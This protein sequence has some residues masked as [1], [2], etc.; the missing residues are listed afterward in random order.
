MMNNLEL[1]DV[2]LI[3]IDFGSAYTKVAFRSKPRE[4]SQILTDLNLAFDEDHICIPSILASTTRSDGVRWVCGPD[5]DGLIEGDGIKIHRNWKQAL[6]REKGSPSPGSKK[7]SD[8]EVDEQLASF[9][10]DLTARSKED[11]LIRSLARVFEIRPR[12]VRRLVMTHEL[13]PSQLESAARMVGVLGD[14]MGPLPTSSGLAVADSTDTDVRLVAIEFFK[15]LREYVQDYA[16]RNQLPAPDQTRVRICGPAF[17]K[18]TASGTPLGAEL[19]HDI[20]VT[21]GWQ[22]DSEKWFV[23]E[24]S[25]NAIGTLTHGK[26]WLWWPDREPRTLSIHW[27]QM[28]QSKAL[29]SAFSERKGD[30]L[31]CVVDVGAFTTDFAVLRFNTS[32]PD[33]PPKTQS[34]SVRLGI[35]K[36]DEE[37]MAQLPA[38]TASIIKRFNGNLWEDFKRRVY[39]RREPFYYDNKQLCAGTEREIIDRIIHEF[40]ERAAQEADSFLEESGFDCIDQLVMTGGGSQIPQVSEAVYSRL[41]Q[42]RPRTFN[43]VTVVHVPGQHLLASMPARHVVPRDLSRG[44]TALGCSNVFFGHPRTV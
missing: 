2:P 32:N 35:A 44:A 13:D 16:G 28:F 37:I 20:L 11:Q 8:D 36:L 38:E 43:R 27:G 10:R 31:L 41:R 18:S 17:S 23:T 30:H 39:S 14:S 15:W 5:A 24:P 19:L 33:L 29:R 9:F 22:P 7:L 4:P 21:T 26:N 1:P 6:F 3:G 34:H 25:A 42:T 12:V 40:A